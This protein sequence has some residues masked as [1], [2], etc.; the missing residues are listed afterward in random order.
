MIRSVYFVAAVAILSLVG[1]KR[2]PTYHRDVAPIVARRCIRCHSGDGLSALPRLDSYENVVS[3]APKIKYAVQRRM[4]PPWG[5]D[6]TGICRTWRDAL[7]LGD[8]ELSTLVSWTE[9]G[10]PAGEPVGHARVRPDP[11]PELAH[12]DTTLDLGFDYKPGLGP[13]S[14][15][16]FV[17]DPNLDRDRFLTGIRVR[18]SDPRMLAQIT[19]FAPQTM[20]AEADALTLDQDD[21]APGYSCYGSPRVDPA[22][23]VASWTWSTPAQI[24]PPGTGIRL[25]A[26]RKLVAQ[27][28]YNVM[29]AGL[30][31]SSRTA[32]DLQFDEGVREAQFLP[33]SPRGIQLAP[34]K[35]YAEAS[36]EMTMTAPTTIFGVAPRMHSLGR[37]MQLDRF[38]GGAS[39]SCAGN[40]DH[41]DFYR[42]RLFTYD[43][44]LRVE[45]GDRLRVSCIY[46][47]E[48]RADPVLQGEDI[49]DEECTAYLY[50]APP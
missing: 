45:A 44:P 32:I 17:V 46:N 47:T 27:V 43:E 15:R 7:W 41:W 1:C 22:T 50:V 14:Y 49:R 19:L 30:S 8:A 28:H 25:A 37:T 10:T 31:A 24:F 5:A 9:T 16:C 18:F 48:G 39:P 4:M 34:G 42:Q 13:T 33:L 29:T 26:H 2:G 21:P 6:D 3:A 20:A 12:V 11:I 23:L 38:H 35:T 40:F 36:G